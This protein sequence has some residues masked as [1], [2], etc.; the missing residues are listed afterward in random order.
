MFSTETTTMPAKGQQMI[1]TGIAIALPHGT[2]A[3]IAP[4]SGLAFRYGITTNTGVIDADYR[5]E[6]KVLLVNLKE[7]DYEVKEGDRIAQ[8]IIERIYDK[9]FKEVKQLDDTERSTS[10]FGSTEQKEQKEPDI[11]LISARAFGKMYKRGDSAGIF[12]LRTAE[13]GV[14]CAATTISTE[15]AIKAGKGGD[16]ISLKQRVPR[17]YHEILDIFEEGERQDL[18]PHRES[19]H[20]IDL[21]Q[22]QTAPFKP[23]YPLDKEKLKALNEYLRKNID[24]GWIRASSSSAGAPILFVRKKDGGLRLWVDYRGLNAVTHKV[25]YLIPHISEAIDRLRTAK[26]FTKLDIKNSYHNSRIRTGNEWKTAF[27]TRYGLFEYTVMPFGLTNAPATFQRWI[28]RILS[29]E[30]DI[31]CIAYLDDVLIY[32]DTLEQNEKDVLR[33]MKR[34]KEAGIKLTPTKCKFH[35]EET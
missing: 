14:T 20:A 17:Y 3:R 5:G 32:S 29:Q 11:E 8:I 23:L 34:L 35:K 15:L 33:I 30:L 19:D 4:R 12:N 26:Y 27:R 31:C 25:R 10:G 18:P 21:E 2:Y 16:K 28:N 1:G 22:G 6:V 7:K 24:R 13:E 9:D